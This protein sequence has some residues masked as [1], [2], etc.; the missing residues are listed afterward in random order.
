MI[1]SLATRCIA[2]I[3]ETCFQ[4]FAARVESLMPTDAMAIYCEKAPVIFPGGFG[5]VAASPVLITRTTRHQGEYF[6]GTFQWHCV[7]V[8][9]FLTPVGSADDTQ[10]DSV[11]LPLG[12]HEYLGI[13]KGVARAG[14][15]HKR[16]GR[17]E[18]TEEQEEEKWILSRDRILI[19][20][21]FGRWTSSCSE[22]I[23]LKRHPVRMETYRRD[24]NSEKNADLHE[25][26]TVRSIIRA[27]SG[28]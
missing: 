25:T 10:P 21:C 7:T 1:T 27:N 22:N 28:T 26:A 13:Q 5:I 9:A 6:S 11:K 19:E 14:L 12:D 18:V 15:S 4:D 3:V 8:R 20:N 16:R 23:S 24:A 17:H 2:S